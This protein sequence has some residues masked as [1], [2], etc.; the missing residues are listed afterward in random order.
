MIDTGCTLA[1]AALLCYQLGNGG[2][3]GK[4]KKCGGGG[5]GGSGKGG[6]EEEY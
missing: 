2:G 4:E 3:A 6:Y 5:G 1:Y